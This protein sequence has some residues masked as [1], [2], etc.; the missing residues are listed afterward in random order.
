MSTLTQVPRTAWVETRGS[1]PVPVPE[2]VAASLDQTY[3][4]M[5]CFELV[6]DDEKDQGTKDFINAGRRYCERKGKRFVYQ[7]DTN[8]VGEKILRYHMADVRPRRRRA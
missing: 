1:K 4:D 5:S 6:I 8:G 7:F 2:E 3:E